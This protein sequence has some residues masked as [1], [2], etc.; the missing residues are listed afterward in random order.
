MIVT[1]QL[2]WQ[3]VSGVLAENMEILVSYSKTHFNLVNPYNKKYKGSSAHILSKAIYCICKKMG[4]VTYIDAFSEFNLVKGKKY[5]LFIGIYANYNKIVEN[6]KCPVKIYFAVNMHPKARNAILLKHLLENRINP[7]LVSSWDFV[8]AKEISRAVN[9]ADYIVAVGNVAVYNSYVKYGV[10]R[11]KI[12]L[13][14]YSVL[15]NVKVNKKYGIKRRFLY[16]ASEI[17]LRKG[18]DSLYTLFTSDLMRRS[19]YLLDIVGNAHQERYKRLISKLVKVSDGKVRNHGWVNSSSVKYKEILAQNYFLIY[20]T[21][22]EGQAGTLLDSM[23]L[24]VIPLTTINSGIDF[25]PLG[26]LEL[27]K[28]SYR[29]QNLLKRTL[30][31]KNKYVKD[32]SNKTFD[33]YKSF[34]GNFPNNLNETIKGCVNGNLN[35]KISIVL[36]IFNKEKTI[37][38]LLKL[39]HK[40]CREYKNVELIIIF[41]GCKD[42]TEIITRRFFRNMNDYKVIYRKTPDIF[43]VKTNNIGLKLATG[44]YCIVLQDDNY[45]YDKNIF[46]EIANLMDKNSNIAILGLLAGVNYYPRGTK[47]FRGKGQIVNNQNEVYWRQ[48]EKTDPHLKDLFFQADACMRPFVVRKDFLEKHGY[49]DEIYSPLYQD[50]IDLCFRAR[51]RGYDVYAGLFDI[52]NKILTIGS[53]NEK[54]HNLFRSIMKRNTDI[55]YSRWKPTKEKTYSSIKRTKIYKTGLDYIEQYCDRISLRENINKLFYLLLVLV[56]RTKKKFGL[57]FA[58][59]KCR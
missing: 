10:S 44:K 36:P 23:S 24:G 55:F 25:H 52:K 17:G 21:L 35:P 1:L 37:L 57:N 39:L 47:N 19:D 33:Y 16:V 56:D 31:I 30:L 6:I 43:E 38:R 14:N 8:D 49:L 41:D 53:Y 22:E 20:P 11:N 5:D 42:K 4:N 32:L 29:N 45:V 40:V 7:M 13:I 58:I 2:L 3:E 9:A 27:K 59:F 34:H 46:F 26:I 12:K 15:N 28:R 54:K 51:S 18:F 48:D 50:D